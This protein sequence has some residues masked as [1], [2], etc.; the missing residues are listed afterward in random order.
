MHPADSLPN[1]IKNAIGN[2][3]CRKQCSRKALIFQ[4]R[5]LVDDADYTINEPD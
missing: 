3:N 5:Q 2:G 4:I 1:T